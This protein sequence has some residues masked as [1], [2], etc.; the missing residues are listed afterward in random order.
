M[1]V[2]DKYGMFGGSLAALLENLDKG[3]V[4][5]RLGCGPIA[6]AEVT[7]LSSVETRGRNRSIV[8]SFR[9]LMLLDP[10]VPTFPKLMVLEAG[11]PI[12]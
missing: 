9:I 1:G 11:L 8:G 6:N 2:Y 4:F 3:L 7:T 5:L 10:V 12:S